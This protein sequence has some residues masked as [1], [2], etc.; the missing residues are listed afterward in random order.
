MWSGAWARGPNIAGAA[1]LAVEQVNADSTLLPGR[2]LIFSWEDSGC[3]AQQALA[4][5]GKLNEMSSRP[6][7]AS[8]NAIIG[9]ACST[10]CE[11]TSYLSRKGAACH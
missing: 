2:M 7:A 4:A 6:G 3:S 10:A 11:V 9:P 1:A 8:N 5:M